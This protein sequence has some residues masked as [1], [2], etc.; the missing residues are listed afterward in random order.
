MNHFDA[1]D[2]SE[3]YSEEV[4]SL[5]WCSVYVANNTEI[6]VTHISFI[7][8]C[9][10]QMLDKSLAL[11]LDEQIVTFTLISPVIS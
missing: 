8:Y 4:I 1:V 9:A 5:F 11:L 10:T 6:Y 7:G 3:C 2:F